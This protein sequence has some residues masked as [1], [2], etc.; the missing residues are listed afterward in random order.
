M[1]R[2]F[3][4]AAGLVPVAATGSVRRVVTVVARGRS[5]KLTAVADRREKVT[6]TICDAFLKSLL[7]RDDAKPASP[8]R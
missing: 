1:F 4:L 2:W 5:F 8:G 7:L 3:A 6:D